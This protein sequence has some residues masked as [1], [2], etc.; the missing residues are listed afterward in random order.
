MAGV[1]VP[2]ASRALNGGVRG[3]QSGSTELRDRVFSAA[4]SLGY[5]VNPAAQATKDGWSRTVA[6]VVSSIDDFGAATMISGM[7][8]AAEKRGVSVAVRTT[9]DDA[10][11]E[12]EML[13]RLRG[14]RH[15]AVIFATSRTTDPHREKVVAERL[16]VLRDQGTRV[17]VIGD[18]ELGFATVTVNNRA[19][20]RALAEGLVQAGRRRFAILTGPAE[21][22]TARD[23]V[24]GFLD[25]L[26]A[27]GLDV[28][29]GDIVRRE[30]SRDGGYDAIRSL[31][32]RINDFDVVA[33]MSDTMAVGAIARLRQK[34]IPIPER[35]EVTGFDHVPLL[36]DVIPRFSTVEIPFGAFG[37][38]GLSLAFDDSAAPAATIALAATPIIHGQRAVEV[39]NTTLA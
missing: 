5:A 9:H 12:L 36:G 37:E 26:R 1:S 30:F 10:E 4:R 13:T 39:A 33:A 38:A 27:H 32:D 7:I 35:V 8:H 3:T 28:S 23:R 24:D 14:E 11:E 34:G 20:A 29:V 25:G 15:R 21:E 16:R 17:V 18:N 31:E 19:A 2:T 6:V 22:V